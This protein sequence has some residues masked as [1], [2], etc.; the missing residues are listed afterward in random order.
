MFKQL[1][2]SVTTKKEE[3]IEEKAKEDQLREV[4]K[5]EWRLLLRDK[6]ADFVIPKKKVLD[7]FDP[8]KLQMERVKDLLV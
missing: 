3:R 5:E 7:D 4:D 6:P 1:R 2:D 8:N